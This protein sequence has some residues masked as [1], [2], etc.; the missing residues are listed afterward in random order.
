MPAT[1]IPRSRWRQLRDKLAMVERSLAIAVVLA[2]IV[3]MMQWLVWLQRDTDVVDSFAGPPRS[4]YT[5]TDFDMVVLDEK[6][7]LAFTV[8]APRLDKHPFLGTF[9]LEQPR[10]RL[11]DGHGDEWK[12]QSASGWIRAD[13]KELRLDGKVDAKRTPTRTA[14]AVN[15]LSERLIALLDT[16][17]LRSDLA[18]TVR[19]PGSIL[20][21]TGMDADLNKNIFALHHEVTGRYDPKLA[22][23]KPTAAKP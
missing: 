8:V 11:I 22:P 7:K 14:T 5:L 17:Q 3:L 23:A 2:A 12:T 13:A 18:V 19:T 4:D 9:A 20:R 6:G 15:I 1:A 16:N 21:G 10:V